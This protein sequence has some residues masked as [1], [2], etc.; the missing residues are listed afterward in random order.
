M[1]LRSSTSVKEVTTD[2]VEVTR[3]LELAVEPEHVTELLQS[4]KILMQL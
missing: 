2:V 4:C 1:T 3:E